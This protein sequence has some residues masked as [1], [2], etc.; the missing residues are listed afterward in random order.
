MDKW[1]A[2]EEYYDI[3]NSPKIQYLRMKEAFHKKCKTPWGKYGSEEPVVAVCDLLSYLKMT[4]EFAEEYPF[5]ENDVIVDN[6]KFI[7]QRSQYMPP[8]RQR[9]I[10][11][12]YLVGEEATYSEVPH[13]V[14]LDRM[15]KVLEREKMHGVCEYESSEWK[16]VHRRINDEPEPSD[17]GDTESEV[18]ASQYSE[19]QSETALYERGSVWSIPGKFELK[20]C[21]RASQQDF[22][23]SERLSKEV[24][25]L[26][27]SR[28][29]VYTGMGSNMDVSKSVG[30]FKSKVETF[31][32]DFQG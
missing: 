6:T 7:Y 24:D 14:L 31:L 27:K 12:C 10:I 1:T 11:D 32:K 21:T 23:I 30:I 18:D 3:F 9:E 29:Y 20:P 13:D 26:W 5:F 4:K 2:L 16:K 15:K 8:E 28:T 22:E 19:D 17:H 25:G